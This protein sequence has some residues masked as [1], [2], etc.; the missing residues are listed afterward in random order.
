MISKGESFTNANL[1][2]T[3]SNT[4]NY[5]NLNNDSGYKKG[6]NLMRDSLIKIVLIHRRCVINK[7]INNK[8]NTISK[9]KGY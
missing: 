9:R 7:K 6:S 4:F 5:N 1:E 2:N 8:Q 3:L